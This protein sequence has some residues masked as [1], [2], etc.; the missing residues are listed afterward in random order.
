MVVVV[1]KVVFIHVKEAPMEIVA[2]D[3]VSVVLEPIG[4]LSV[5]IL[6]MELVDWH[7]IHHHRVQFLQQYLGH[8]RHL[9]W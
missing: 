6:C 5:V 9:L 4:V 3:L 7:S 2:P 8:P 1:L